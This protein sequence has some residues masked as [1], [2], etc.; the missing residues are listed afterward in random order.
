[1]K[2]TKISK[3]M[4]TLFAVV[5]CFGPVG[6]ADPLGTAFTYQGRL[7]D[8]NNAADGLYD[9][10][11]KLYDAN[12]AGNKLGVDVN[13]PEADVIDGYFTVELDFGSSVF[14]GNA[15]WLQIGVRQGN[16]SDPNA[17]NILSPRQLVTPTPYAIKAKTFTVPADVSGST[18]ASN[19]VIKATNTGNGYGLYGYSPSNYGVYGYSGTVPGVYG[20]SGSAEGV[21]GVNGAWG[22][23]GYLGGNSYGVYGYGYTGPG[24]YFASGGTY[25]LIVENGRVGIGIT[26]PAEELHVKGSG[27]LQGIFESTNSSGGV[28]LV[29]NNGQAYEM[30]AVNDGNFVIY[31]RT[32]GRYDMTIDTNGHT[33]LAGNLHVD[34][35]ITKS[36]TSGTRNPAIPIAYANINSNG[37]V[38]AG[39]PNVSC[40]Y[41]ESWNQYEISITGEN[42]DTNYVTVATPG[43]SVKH[44]ATYSSSNKLCVVIHDSSNTIGKAPFSFVV[45]KP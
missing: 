45:Y 32:D 43:A 35:S 3:I 31:D 12:I 36:Y 24:G 23:Y 29:A 4:M 18:S 9:F 8:S 22:N 44:I 16:F 6:L 13:K 11:F 42:Y 41:N 26:T 1:M 30:Q 27:Y 17:Y 39:T 20:Y 5:L 15:V 33:K 21:Y 14:D 25:G 19:A 7:I 28:K 37:S 2:C 34:G 38:I 40:T 10:Q